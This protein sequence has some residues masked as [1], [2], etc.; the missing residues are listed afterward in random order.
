MTREFDPSRFDV[1]AFARAGATLAGARPLERCERLHAE[2]AAQVPEATVRWEAKGERRE[3]PAGTAAAPWLHLRAHA[4]LALTCQR[5][6][7]PVEVALS[8]D[9]WFRFAADEAIAAAQDETAEEDVLALRRDFDLHELVEDE[10]LMALPITP[11]H[12][13][14]PAPVQLSAADPEFES[15]SAQRPNPFAVLDALRARKPPE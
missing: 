4:T 9:R 11:R 13:I 10:L 7:A 12:E 6:L 5:C 14:C 15:A 1:D 3:G 8:V 2:V